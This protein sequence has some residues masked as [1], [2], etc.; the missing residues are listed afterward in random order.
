M[1]TMVM[2]L[3]LSTLAQDYSVLANQSVAVMLLSS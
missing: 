2:T 1:F 3:K